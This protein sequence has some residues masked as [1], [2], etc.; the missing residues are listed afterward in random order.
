MVAIQVL[1]EPE[2]WLEPSIEDD[3]APVLVPRKRVRP[4]PDRATR[5]RRRR[6]AV[7]V[8][9]VVLLAAL[10][11]LTKFVVSTSSARAVGETPASPI[12]EAVYV[13]QPGDTLWSIAQRIAPNEDPRPI[14]DELRE[15]NEGVELEVGTRLSVG[16]L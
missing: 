6:L 7:L 2:P 10:V 8:V 15:L 1:A 11:S 9:A 14:V 4:L 3:E 12:T 13:V 16:E 5:F